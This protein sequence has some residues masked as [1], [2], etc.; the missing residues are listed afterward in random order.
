MD[1]PLKKALHVSQA[2]FGGGLVV[3]VANDRNSVSFWGMG[4]D[5]IYVR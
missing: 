5:P 2:H 4:G 3:L 1:I